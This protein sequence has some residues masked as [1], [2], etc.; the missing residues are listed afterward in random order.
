[1]RRSSMGSVTGAKPAKALS[2]VLCVDLDG[3]L[4]RGNVLWECI[5]LLL[6]TRPITLL[7]LPFWLLKGRAFLK[8]QVAAGVQ[9]NPAR[10]PYREQVLDLIREERTNGRHVA[11]VTASDRRIAEVISGY[12]GL[13][14]EVHASDGRLNLKGTN[15][16]AFLVRHYSANG[17][18]YIGDSAADL[19]VWRSALAAYVVGTESRARQAAAVTTLKG[20]I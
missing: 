7:R 20:T 1:M 9:L 2:P 8:Q 15:K 16:A 19:E 4:I 5:L 10:L 17:F 3:T 13:F 11:L 6:K 12:L 14:D 18:E